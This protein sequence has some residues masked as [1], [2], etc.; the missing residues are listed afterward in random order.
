[1]SKVTELASSQITPSDTLAV[2]L[3]EADETPAAVIIRWPVKPSVIHP[4]RFPDT[5]ATIARLFAEAHT[6]L[7]SIN[8][9]GAATVSRSAALAGSPPDRGIG[10]SDH[11]PNS[12]W[13][14][15][16]G[17]WPP[18][19]VNGLSDVRLPGSLLCAL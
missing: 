15:G 1:M 3:V 13:G 16:R 12:S 18:I 6:V 2:E 5:A 14:I 9:S 7:A 17:R 19:R 8:Q 10:L 11:R 4:R